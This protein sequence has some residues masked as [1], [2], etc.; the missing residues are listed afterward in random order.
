[1]NRTLTLDIRPCVWGEKHTGKER[2]IFKGLWIQFSRFVVAL[3]VCLQRKFEPGKA[4]VVE[5]RL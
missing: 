1:M 4:M 5:L 2:L 3:G